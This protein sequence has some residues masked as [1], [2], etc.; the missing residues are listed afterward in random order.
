MFT[1]VKITLY[2]RVDGVV[3]FKERDNKSYYQYCIWSWSLMKFSN[4]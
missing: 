2:A 4:N 1:S 3:K